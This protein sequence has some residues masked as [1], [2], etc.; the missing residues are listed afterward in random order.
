MMNTASQTMRIDI[1][2]DIKS[3]QHPS[4]TKRQLMPQPELPPQI[5]AKRKGDSSLG[6]SDFQELFQS[7]YD[8]AIILTMAGKV[9]D[10]NVR[11]TT[12]LRY[13]REELIT[14]E[15]MDIV[16]GATQAM[17]TTIQTTLKKDRFLLIQAYCARKDQALFP[18]E[19]SVNPLKVGGIDYFCC[20]IRDIT[21]RRQAED[22]LKTIHAAI[23]N[24]ATG[25]VIANLDGL[26]DYANQ[27]AGHLC[28]ENEPLAGR[29][30][31]DLLQDDLAYP[32]MLAAI[33]A[34]TNW[35]G[36]V[37]MKYQQGG[38][39]YIQISA[40]PNRDAEDALT[41]MILSLL[42][43]SDR[44]RAQE[45]EKHAERQNVMLQSLGAACHHLGQP[46]TVLL[47]SLELMVRVKDSDKV[48][49]DELLVSSMDA[50]ES[51]RK[52]LHNLND[53]TEYK[54][55]PYIEGQNPV[56]GNPSRIL[57]VITQ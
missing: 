2:P 51:L 16:S 7:V 45:A 12:F 10:A 35:S 54:T 6:A 4:N 44:I 30:V 9:V 13:S 18:V 52:I 41:G 42:N 5:P 19:I 40:A 17:L 36:E 20:F 31:Q 29:H 1:P 50:A 37:V 43:V 53:I 56:T 27:A 32:A 46:A 11:A 24:A 39:I 33:R 49:G 38:P 55:V 57:D 23:Q 34:G 15:L 26:I 48:L 14:M 21:W 22:I 8:G 25:I 28:H 3:A 47:A